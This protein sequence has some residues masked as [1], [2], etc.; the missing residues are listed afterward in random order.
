MY[1]KRSTADCDASRGE[2]NMSSKSS[3]TYIIDENYNVIHLNDT[4]KELYPSLQIGKKCY[5]C[6]MGLNEPCPPCPVAN[7][8]HG[9]QTYL[10]PIRNIC[11]TVDAVDINLDNGKVGHALVMSTVGD[12][13]TIA[14]KLPRTKAELQKLLE[15]EYFD[16]LT[17]GFTRKGFIRETKRVFAHADKTDYAMI[18]FDIHN[19]KAINDIFGIEGGDQV[20]RYVFHH[21]HESWLHPVV[22]ARIESD[23]FL[24]LVPKASIQL[25][26]MNELL[27]LDW[28]KDNRTVHLHLRCGIY[29]VENSQSSISRMVEW[30]ILAKQN[31]DQDKYGSFAQ[32][33]AAMREKYIDQAEVLS[34]FSSSLQ[35]EHFKVYYQPIIEAK[36]CSLCGAEALVRWQHPSRGFI[37]PDHFIPA[38]ESSG[39]ITDLDLYVLKHVY[40]FQKEQMDRQI[41]IVPVSVNLSRQD[42]YNQSF[43]NEIFRIAETSSLP[44]GKINY[45]VTETAVA[46]LKE[47]C[48]YLL[49][50]LRKTGAKV[51]LDDF[52]SGYSSLGMIGDYAFDIIKI[53]KS[54]V[55]QIETK[56]TVRAVIDA[57]I[58][59]CHTIGMRTVAEGVENKAQL[60]YLKAHGCDYIQG[61]YYSKPL[62]QQ[63]FRSYLSHAQ[64]S[65]SQGQ[66]Y[67][68]SDIR[69]SFDLDNLMDLVDHSGQFIQVCHPEDYSMVYANAMTRDISGHPDLS[70]HGAKCYQYMLGLDAPCGHCP[71]KLMNGE[72]EKMVEVDDGSHVFSLKARYTT[73]NGK[74]VFME[75]G[76]DITQ[77]KA[78]ERRYADQMRSILEHIPEGQGVFHMDLTADKWLSSGGNAKNARDIQNIKD[79]NTLIRQIGSFVPDEEGQRVF[80]NTFSREAQMQAYAVNKRQIVLETESYYDDRSIR[81][82]RITV[83]LIDN[84]NNNH[85]ESI[86]YGVDISKEK[87]HI[88][89][90]QRERQEASIEKKM[91]Q[92]RINETWKLYTQAERDRRYDV[93]TGLNSRLALYDF[94]K[95]EKESSACVIN[96]VIF[97]D[98]DDFKHINDTYGHA[99]GDACLKAIG[100]TIMDFGA[101]HGISFY[102]YGGEEIVGLCH[103]TDESIADLTRTL[104]DQIH[105]LCILLPDGKRISVTASIG[106]TARADD[107][108]SMIENADQAMYEAKKHGKNQSA[109]LD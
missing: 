12:S 100:K 20:L 43:M 69:E 66:K 80:F 87:T 99:A 52:G 11:E 37:V 93:L 19:F 27:N 30:T 97:L 23:W 21:L 71:M 76:H 56:P 33:N 70:Y 17:E 81:W 36:S 91:L 61:Y 88:E 105:A 108:T 3:G 82:S 103:I 42:F 109:C 28:S 101:D 24:F 46:V 40:A 35:N 4:I 102:R 22:S 47:N 90:L 68:A 39:L 51:L 104:L 63:D 86:L 84:P 60:E 83:H 85:V 29:Y 92:E 49:Q 64:I 34:G 48:A 95:Q 54:F 65:S 55:D 53:D 50:Q 25:D 38:L 59:M 72:D 31:A 15:Q 73:W 89:E 62:S 79:V 107:V 98:V 58:N 74:R 10:D 41:P 16:T 67:S 8:I 57:A 32:F 26:H 6:L 13:E 18:L 14:A 75:Y 94:I 7:H 78:A 96:A 1:F 77:T 106:Y 9:P 45:E 44:E 2:R 5:Q